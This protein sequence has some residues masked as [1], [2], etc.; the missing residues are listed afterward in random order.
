[1]RLI[2]S[3]LAL[4]ALLIAF[5]YP[6]LASRWFELLE[7]K[8]SAFARRRVLS[9]VVV[10]LLTLALRIALM[11]IEPIPEPI[12]HDEF[13]YLLAADTFAHGRLTNPTHPMW[14]HFETFSIIQ[15]PTYQCFAQPAQGLI[16]AAGKL[17]FGH[18][19]WG[20]WLSIGIMCA[21]ITWALKGWMPSR[22]AVLGGLLAMLRLAGFSYWAN[23]YWGGAA[24]A[25]GG[26]LILGALPRLKCSRRVRDA[27][28]MGVG[29]ALL[30]NNRPSE[31]FVFSLPFAGA[32]LAWMFG[33]NGPPVQV[34][35]RRAVVPL[36]LVLG[37]TAIAITYYCLRV[38]GNPLRMPYQVERQT[39]AVVP[40]MLWQSTSP[41]PMY[42]HELVRRMYASELR[43][44][45][46]ERSLV[47]RML[48]PLSRL[49]WVCSFYL[50]PV[51]ILS[52]V[53]VMFTA[54]HN[55]WPMRLS[56][57]I[58]FLLLTCGFV[59]LGLSLETFYSPH[60]ASPVTGVIF[61]LVVLA[62]RR[63]QR[64]RW[65]GKGSGLF[66]TRAIPV[67]CVVMFVLRL[68]AEPLGIPIAKYFMPAWYQSGP[69]SFGRAAMLTRLQ[70]LPGRQ[71][72]LVRYQPGHDPFEEWVYNDADIDAAK[73]VWARDM[74]P[75]ENE[76]LI[77]YF[78]DRHV[79]VLEADQYP[80]ALLPYS[81]AEGTPT[82]GELR[83]RPDANGSLTKR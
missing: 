27:L 56:K 22:W 60:Y 14:V 24:G 21:A 73:V 59:L 29:L 82:S 17:A 72:V 31:G 78:R 8:F 1:M 40:Y 16:L 36:C 74:S 51:L 2:E 63:L 76:P 49:F 33:K 80:P 35:L 39:Y 9:V 83:R 30:A 75:A 62:M 45:M 48:V 19:F 42:H 26:S 12:V 53:L 20:V 70:Q 10:G 25:I 64:W 55:L 3:G 41:P 58:R 4:A 38:T 68:S 6:S 54:R 61:G 37:V 28:V 52:V 5:T 67:I 66:I 57:R 13:G 65:H 79:W 11:P 7:R 46:Q 77:S 69:H 18:P 81:N 71:L 47:G 43:I 34:S 44:Y 23:S 32:L 50:G 15:K